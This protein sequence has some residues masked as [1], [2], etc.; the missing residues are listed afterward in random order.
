MATRINLLPSQE[1]DALYALPDFSEEEQLI[2]FAL[3]AEL[4]K[5]MAEYRTIKTKIYFLLQVGYFRSAR[6]FFDFTLDSVE[7]DVQYIYKTYF[8]SSLSV[9]YHGKISK[10]RIYKQRKVILSLFNFKTWSESL[11]IIED[12]LLQLMRTHPKNQD[13]LRELLAFIESKSIILPNYRTLQDAFT[14]AMSTERQRLSSIVSEALTNKHCVALDNLLLKDGLISKLAVLKSDQKNFKLRAIRREISKLQEIRELYFLSTEILPKLSLSKNCKTYYCSLVTQYSAYRIK[15]YTKAYAR[16]L[17]L[18]YIH[19]RYQ[20]ISD[21]LILTLKYHIRK[22]ESKATEHVAAKE[23]EHNANSTMNLP[24]V[25][26]LLRWLV[27]DR[28]ENN[29]QYN[30]VLKDSFRILPKN[31]FLP[32]ADFIDNKSFDK[33]EVFWQFFITHTRKI[34][35]Y[36]RSIFLAL[37]YSHE[38]PKSKKLKSIDYFKA[39]I[40]SGKLISEIDFSGLLKNVVS[41][42]KR[43]YMYHVKDNRICVSTPKLEFFVYKKIMDNMEDGIMFCN[44]SFSF[45]SLKEDF[46]SIEKP[47]QKEKIIQDLGY[48]RILNFTSTRLEELDSILHRAWITTN[49]NIELGLNTSIKFKDKLDPSGKWHLT[50]ETDDDDTESVLNKLSQMEIAN[51]VYYIFKKYNLLLVFSH[52]KPYRSSQ[53]FELEYVV[54]C[55]LASAFGCSL[56]KMFQISDLNLHKLRLTY[57]NAIR[58]ETLK[59]ANDELVS[60]LSELKIFRDWDLIPGRLLSDSDGQ[61]YETK[62]DTIQSRHSSKFFGFGKGIVVSSLVTNIFPLTVK[63]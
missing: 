36:L 41:A 7:R 14:K 44:H 2:H 54:G 11:A 30:A 47:E 4:R 27:S 25:A 57:T 43:Q 20:Q 8:S 60:R 5:I 10:D 56:N 46:T 24:N 28:I 12:R 26:N 62:T 53:I 37:D 49:Q 38:N 59:D 63:S 22:L 35:L 40:K 9:P 1:V 13:S 33:E 6:Q 29:A 17:L 23:R 45:K 61:K 19:V 48:L 55:I 52:I 21:F 3:S 15:Q 51:I 39:N 31:Q 18:C 58:V 50:Y 16:V 34:A 42:K 32:M